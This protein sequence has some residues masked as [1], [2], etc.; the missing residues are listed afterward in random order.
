MSAGWILT[1]AH[2]FALAIFAENEQ[3]KT[4]PPISF[5]VFPV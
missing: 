5:T 2:T 1:E 3:K 4:A